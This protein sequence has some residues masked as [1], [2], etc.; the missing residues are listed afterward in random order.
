MA[1]RID[2]VDNEERKRTY[3]KHGIASL[4]VQITNGMA[5]VVD[6][7]GLTTEQ[8]VEAVCSYLPVV[9]IA[10]VER[11]R[12]E[13]AEQRQQID[14]LTA[15]KNEALAGVERLRV[16]AYKAWACLM[17]AD[18]ILSLIA[19]RYRSMLPDDLAREAGES[20]GECRKTTDEL[21]ALLD[22]DRTVN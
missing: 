20:Y 21:K 10:E 14:G 12:E 2:P 11:L 22:K 16:T 13:N 1:E 5:S 6:G 19:N 18:S 4:D 9:P 15:H 3:V 7:T 8:A 17:G